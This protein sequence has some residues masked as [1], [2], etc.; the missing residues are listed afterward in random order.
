MS[1]RRPLPLPGPYQQHLEQWLESGPPEVK[2]S[3]HELPITDTLFQGSI[4][5]TFANGV[6]IMQCEMH[7]RPCCDH[8][9]DPLTELWY[10]SLGEMVRRQ[11][12][13][14]MHCD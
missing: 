10:K 14:M 12:G 13:S 7:N 6:Q 5:I 9:P 3:S 4:A 2:H 8:L 1:Y 11:S